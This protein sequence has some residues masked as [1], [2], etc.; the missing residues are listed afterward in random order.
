MSSAAAVEIPKQVEKIEKVPIV[1]RAS[2]LLPDPANRV[3]RYASGIPARD[4]HPGLGLK[5]S[6]EFSEDKLHGSIELERNP[7]RRNSFFITF[8]APGGQTVGRPIS[9]KSLPEITGG[10][11]KQKFEALR[12]EAVSGQETRT[13]LG[14]HDGEWHEVEG[15]YGTESYA[16]KIPDAQ[17]FA[18]QCMGAL[19]SPNAQLFYSAQPSNLG[20]TAV[21]LASKS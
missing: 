13:M 8:R 6:Q 16:T 2:G 1:E 20:S 21:H 5:G 10:N 17:L 12:V 19:E 15:I 9:Q 3:W 14:L 18:E 11:D 7:E 4:G